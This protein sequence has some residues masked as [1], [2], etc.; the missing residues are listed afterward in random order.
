VK[1]GP[2]IS[3]L[4]QIIPFIGV[5]NLFDNQYSGNVR[6]NAFGGRYFEPAPDRDVYAGMP[7]VMTLTTERCSRGIQPAAESW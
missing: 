7:C 4:T 1:S 5:N 3:P 2:T 6:I